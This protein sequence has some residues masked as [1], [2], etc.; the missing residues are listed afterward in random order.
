MELILSIVSYHRFTSD[1]EAKKSIALHD[2]SPVL[3]IGRS[4]ACEWCLPDPERVIS[5]QHARIEGQGNGF[6]ITDTST[7][8]LF[9]NRSVEALGKDNQYELR[10]GDFISFGDYEIEVAIG[11]VAS[12]QMDAPLA[13]I[14]VDAPAQTAMPAEPVSQSVPEE[15]DFG[16][17]TDQLASS[18]A[19]QQGGLFDTPVGAPS[20]S[21]LFIGDLEDNFIAPDRQQ[22]PA[23]AFDDEEA[24]LA[25]PENW[26]DNLLGDSSSDVPPAR[27]V[28]PVTAPVAEPMVDTVD[29]PV[30][31][32]TVV[33]APVVEAP[34][35]HAPVVEERIAEARVAEK[36]VV[37]ATMVKENVV[38]PPVA[39]EPVLAKAA[40]PIPDVVLPE[41]EPEPVVVPSQPVARVVA[42]T[43]APQQ[44]A[45]Q[46]TAAVSAPEP[47]YVEE[48]EF[49]LASPDPERAPAP[50]QQT[51]ALAPQ[52]APQPVARPA[53]PAA[54]PAA[55]PAVSQP[56][57]LSQP[58]SSAPVSSAPVSRSAAPRQPVHTPT[59]TPQPAAQRSAPHPLLDGDASA[60]ALASFIEG[61]GIDST[62][63]P[64]Q[65]A[66]QWWFE[67][68][69]SMQLLMTGL[70]DSLH[71]RSAFKQNNRLNQTLFKRQEN[72]PLKFSAS[73]EDAIHNLY[74]R[75]SA[76]FLTPER[77]INEAFDDIK[78]HEQA[79]LAGVE[80]SVQ[81]M[82]K[83]LSPDSISRGA[84]EPSFFG[85]MAS[86]S[87][88]A[89]SWAAYVEM[90]E[91]L[92][93]D[94]DSAKHSFYAEDF[95]KAY[96][97]YLKGGK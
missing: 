29:A 28:E 48:D 53:T 1:L 46:P 88:K 78:Q 83:Q 86:G 32:D 75:K 65:H 92:N 17:R 2:V 84:G 72:N 95:V 76:S 61:L 71:Q 9:I 80:G 68:G 52:R 57:T 43:P 49:D 18:Q 27:T 62:M 96:E 35:V 41:P 7:N 30:L 36:P 14:P 66:E 85:R 3:H 54:Q 70:M 63:V 8:G 82:M 73:V 12:A 87:Q 10:D 5:G 24:P 45:P 93:S 56:R 47:A 13:D 33:E 90:Y 21:S 22:D 15:W 81:S 55:Q 44:R 67:M 38:T 89:Q 16:V 11:E 42:P 19:V 58:A 39:K 4:Q 77:A 91:R 34:V 40:A 23:S 60:Q 79:L 26:S 94:L 59:S 6:V 31:A 97:A 50:V 69:A 37:K 20:S 64:D 74:N 51:V 25:I